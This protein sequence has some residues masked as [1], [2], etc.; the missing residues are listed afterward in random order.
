MGLGS[1][2]AWSLPAAGLLQSCDHTPRLRT[3]LG[4]E[5][6]PLLTEIGETILPTTATSPGAGAAGIGEYLL[7]MYQ[8]GLPPEEQAIL[9]EGLNLLDARAAKSLK[10]SFEKA[11]KTERLSLLK[12]FQQEATAHKERNAEVPEAPPHFF[13]VL[14]GLTL[15]GYFTSEIGMTQAREYLPV[16][17]RYEGCVPH[18]NGDKVWAL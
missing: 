14:K 18:G 2:A 13:D 4:T 9:L 17:G 12:E 16:P 7:L 3:T 1:G 10:T 5:D 11:S 8:D 6:L 15:T